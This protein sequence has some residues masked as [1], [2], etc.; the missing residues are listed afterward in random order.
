MSKSGCKTEP[1][2]CRVRTKKFNNLLDLVKCTNLSRLS[3]MNCSTAL[4]T[5]LPDTDPF[6]I[7][8][9]PDSGN[10]FITFENICTKKL[11]ESKTVRYLSILQYHLL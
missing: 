4:M 3:Y 5:G 8:I 6:L 1:W 7:H 2:N 9:P 11:T 10:R